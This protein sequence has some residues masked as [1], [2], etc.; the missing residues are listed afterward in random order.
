MDTKDAPSWKENP[1]PTPYF[2]AVYAKLLYMFHCVDIKSNI[3]SSEST[4]Q[5][6]CWTVQSFASQFGTCELTLERPLKF[7]HGRSKDTK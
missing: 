4:P 1:F 3:K 2:F 6:T 7:Q 5:S